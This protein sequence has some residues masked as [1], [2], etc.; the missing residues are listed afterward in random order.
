[1]KIITK[2]ETPK[3]KCIDLENSKIVYKD[4]KRNLPKTWEEYITLVS[5]INL[6]YDELSL[7]EKLIMLRNY[8]NDCG[9]IELNIN[10]TLY[11]ISYIIKKKKLDIFESHIYKSTPFRFKTR[12]L[13][14]EYCSNFKYEIHEYFL[15][16]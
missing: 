13:A 12:K 6:Y 16:L 3:N 5:P 11:E 9:K 7:Y 2:V 8:Y 14:E 15:N 10:E 1:M 4:I